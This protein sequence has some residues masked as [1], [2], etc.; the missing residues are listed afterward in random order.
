MS[1]R[2]PYVPRATAWLL[3][4]LGAA[5]LAGPPAPQLAPGWALAGR[6]GKIMLVIV[7][8]TQAGERAAYDR[9]IAALCA[10]EETCFVNFFTNSTNA[11]V[12]VPL[13]DAIDHEATAVLRRSA[14]Q[15]VDSFRW[16]CR[17]K[18]L[19]GDCF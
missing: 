17:L 10:G 6:Q 14:K 15:G 7:P 11:P 1:P 2:P 16:S 12:A 18:K 3:A 4:A 9:Q 8:A 5:A 19:D 13:P